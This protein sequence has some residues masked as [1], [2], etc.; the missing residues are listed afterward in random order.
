MTK[1]VSTVENYLLFQVIL[2]QKLLYYLNHFLVTTCK[3]GASQADSD[4]GF[5]V[6][7]DQIQI[8]VSKI[9]IKSGVIRKKTKKV[10]KFATDN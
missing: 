8:I 9:T 1:T 10:V 6:F 7:H 5:V 4:L 3:T 2:G